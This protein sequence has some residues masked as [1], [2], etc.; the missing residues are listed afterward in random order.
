MKDYRISESRGAEF[1]EWEGAKSLYTLEFRIE[2]LTL[3]QKE[4]VKR[5]L[6]RVAELV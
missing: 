6:E 2:G 4:I 5:I 1:Y 3:E